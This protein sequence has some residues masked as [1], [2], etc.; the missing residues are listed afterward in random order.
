M[1]SNTKDFL[2]PSALKDL[3]SQKRL[4]V[5]SALGL[6][7]SGPLNTLGAA[8]NQLS[9]QK[10]G[11]KAT[12]IVNR[13]INYSNYCILSCKFCS[14]SR[15]K[16]DQ[17]GFELS[18]E[19]MQKKAQEALALG[20]TELHI[21]G[22]LHPSLPF[23]YYKDMLKGLKEVSSDL[24]LKC[25][26]AI[27]ILHLAWLSKQSVD[28]TLKS[29][30]D[31]GLDALTG[32][33]AEIFQSDV[34]KKIAAGKESASEYLDVHRRWHLLGGK[35]TCTMLYGHVESLED[36]ID[37]LHQLRELQDETG[38]FSGFVPLPYQ[39]ENNA[40]PVKHPPTGNDMLRTIAIS[41][42]FLDNFDHI[43]AYWVGMGLNMAQIALNYGADDIH[44]TIVEEHIF[45]MAGAGSA[46]GQ[47]EAAMREAIRE[48]G[49]EPVQRDTCY[50]PISKNPAARHVS[51]VDTA[52]KS[53][54]VR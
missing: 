5:E 37:H 24:E 54:T 39:P 43:T 20:I 27:E 4:S 10:N 34:R 14:F 25:F 40:I 48:A 47:T 28:D 11:Q 29:L 36:R 19:E 33:G 42:L 32:G 50:Q 17:D 1:S 9:V 23:T 22:G 12:Y 35:S 44:G 8:A 16:R 13:Y 18:L 15:K 3:I 41:R 49:K 51:A 30:K 6:Y 46:N 7:Q 2:L 52:P 38:G 53:V 45:R 21:V 26:T 31:C